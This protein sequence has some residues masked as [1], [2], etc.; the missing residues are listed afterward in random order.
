MPCG[1]SHAPPLPLHL[2]TGER[3][4]R[5]AHGKECK[6]NNNRPVEN[7]ILYGE[8]IWNTEAGNG[9]VVISRCQKWSERC[10]CC[11][12][13]L[14]SCRYCLWQTGNASLKQTNK[15]AHLLWQRAAAGYIAEGHACITGKKRCLCHIG[16][17][18]LKIYSLSPAKLGCMTEFLP[19]ASQIQLQW[20]FGS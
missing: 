2:N 13:F 19:F 10:A 12:W 20:V 8:G 9:C 4:R 17:C 18:T 11:P 1:A 16:F 5:K 14:R 6:L 15:P 7:S 3:R